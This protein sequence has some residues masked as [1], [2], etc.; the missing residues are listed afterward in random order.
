MLPWHPIL[1]QAAD[2]GWLAGRDP[3]VLRSK[4]LHRFCLEFAPQFPLLTP[5][6]AGGKGLQLTQDDGIAAALC[7]RQKQDCLLD[8]RC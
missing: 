8:V 3:Y 6:E 7:P 4:D 5:I 1:E 2:A